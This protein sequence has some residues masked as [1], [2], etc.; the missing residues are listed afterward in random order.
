MKKNLE[1]QG[2]KFEDYLSHLKKTENELMLEYSPEATKRIK[3]ALLLQ[4]IVKKEDIRVSDDDLNK[5]LEDLKKQ[6]AGQA[7][8]LKV[9]QGEEYQGSLKHNLLNDKVIK[10]LKEWNYERSGDKQKS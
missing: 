9:I 7:E 6:Y 3:F 2:A 1:S 10:Q 5:T 4:E 8:I